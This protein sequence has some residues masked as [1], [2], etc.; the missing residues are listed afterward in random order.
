MALDQRL[1]STTVYAAWLEIL[2]HMGK[3]FFPRMLFKLPM[4]DLINSGEQNPGKC[5][6]F[7]LSSFCLFLPHFKSLKTS[8]LKRLSL[9]CSRGMFSS[10]KGDDFCD[11]GGFCLSMSS[12]GEDNSDFSGIGKEWGREPLVVGNWDNDNDC[13]NDQE[14][15]LRQCHFQSA[16]FYWANLPLSHPV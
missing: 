2:S 6:S 9:S 12:E 15:C 1:N 5:F 11:S 3:E 7:H 10:T 13:K 16:Y 4:L 8:F 14:T